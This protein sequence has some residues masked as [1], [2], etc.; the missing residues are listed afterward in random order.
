MP[1]LQ[2]RVS[3]VT[4]YNGENSSKKRVKAGLTLVSKDVQMAGNTRRT[5]G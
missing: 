2:S 1:S 5:A 3:A 4:V